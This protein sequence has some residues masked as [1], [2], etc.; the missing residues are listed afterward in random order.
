MTFPRIDDIRKLLRFVWIEGG[1]WSYRLE[2]VGLRE[3]FYEN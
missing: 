3:S 2:T 1:N